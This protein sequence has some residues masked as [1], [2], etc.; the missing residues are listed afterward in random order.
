MQG[1]Q[2]MILFAA[3]AFVFAACGD[4]KKKTGPTDTLTTGKVDISVDETYKPVIEQQL[5]VFDSSFPEAKI[6]AHY[7]AESECFKD[8][9]DGKA[10]RG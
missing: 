9:F 1:L 8:L 4:D 2:K 6:T 10:H 5:K 7:K 3:A